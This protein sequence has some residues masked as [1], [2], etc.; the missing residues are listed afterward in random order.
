MNWILI[1]GMCLDHLMDKANILVVLVGGLWYPETFS[2]IP[3]D[4][5]EVTGNTVGTGE[6]ETSIKDEPERRHPVVIR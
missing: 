5:T 3:N 6:T 1:G 4:E 2:L